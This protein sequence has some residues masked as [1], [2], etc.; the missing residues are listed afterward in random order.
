M[1]TTTGGVWV[2]KKKHVS[3]TVGCKKGTSYGWLFFGLFFSSLS[4][5]LFVLKMA[6][7]VF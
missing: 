1:W 7:Y 4:F 3:F 6:N 5:F 2:L